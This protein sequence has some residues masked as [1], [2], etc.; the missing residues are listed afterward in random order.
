MVLRKKAAS[1]ITLINPHQHWVAKPATAAVR[2]CS[3]SRKRILKT[4]RYGSADNRSGSI[5]V[6]RIDSLSLR[7]AVELV[8]A[9]DHFLDSRLLDPNIHQRMF[10][11]DPFDEF[12]NRYRTWFK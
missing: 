3:I 2:Y 7:R 11:S 8:E 6:P 1:T 10:G 9:R 5:D 12:R 4:A